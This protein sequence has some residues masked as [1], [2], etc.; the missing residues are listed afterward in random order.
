MRGL[1][2][3]L[4]LGLLA[5][6]LL[7]LG[8]WGGYQ[9]CCTYRVTYRLSGPA[10][11]QVNYIQFDLLRGLVPYE[12][13]VSLPWE[14]TLTSDRLRSRPAASLRA[15]GDGRST[16]LACEIWVDGAKVSAQSASG[17]VGCLLDP[18]KASTP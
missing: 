10:T 12:E 11:A 3:I 7:G 16:P 4:L 9:A 15:L 2:K 18:A 13:T 1:R 8:G 5:A 6:V 17:A 14:T